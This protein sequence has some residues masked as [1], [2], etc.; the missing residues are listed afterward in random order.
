M[1][2]LSVSYLYEDKSHVGKCNSKHVDQNYLDRYLSDPFHLEEKQ[3]QLMKTKK[4]LTYYILLGKTT[5]EKYTELQKVLLL[6]LSLFLTIKTQEK[7]NINITG[8][9]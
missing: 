6:C 1:L 7:M 5:P 3:P 2:A 9:Y 8:S 4:S